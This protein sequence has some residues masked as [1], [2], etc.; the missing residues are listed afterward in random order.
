V[1]IVADATLQENPVPHR[2]SLH[3][4]KLTLTSPP[5]G[6]PAAVQEL[7]KL[8]VA[9][10]HPVII[11]GEVARDEEGM[12]LLVELAETL[13]APVQGE[14][15][16]MPNRHPLSGGG[17]VRN[18]DVI[19]A[20]N[21]V[22]LYSA[23]N[24]F[25]D[26]QERS[27]TPLIRRGT[28]VVTLSSFDLYEKGN[29]QNVD[30]FTEVDMAITGDPQATL[31][32]LVEACRKLMTADRRRAFDERGK[33]LAAASA[34]AHERALAECAYGWDASPISQRRLAVELWD[35][36]KAKDWASVTVGGGGGR[37]WDV[38]K[39]Y[40][41]MGYV[42]GGG[43]GGDLPIAVG[44]ALAHKKHGRLCVCLQKDGDMMYVPGALW[45]ATHHQIPMLFVMHN[46][47]AYHQEV[48]HV[49]RMAN[50]RQRGIDIA[51][52]G[53]TGTTLRDPNIDFAQLARSM[54]AYGEGPISDPKD[55]RAALVR[56]VARV[57]K[58]EVAL[59][60]TV[61]QPR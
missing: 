13:Q 33:G 7:A 55:L 28:K 19:L 47:R 8:L 1:L 40:R 51:G 57:E 4:P 24:N 48:M 27:S 52:Q 23:L 34:Q 41:T 54:G 20:M 39:F 36:I 16:N 5:A 22:R 18:A 46:N 9:A 56:A 31:P 26:Q 2:S 37:L 38:D 14:G 29:Y 6:D 45:T 11:A 60:D 10:E 43:V 42:F 32:S 25:R 35:V 17:N 58:G 44:G 21:V 12:R 61:V 50:R 53:F 30:R 49:Q 3:V 59:V 15:R